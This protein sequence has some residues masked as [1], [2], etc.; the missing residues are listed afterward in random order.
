MSTA[1]YHRCATALAASLAPEA[2]GCMAVAPLSP[3]EM[4]LKADLDEPMMHTPTQRQLTGPAPF[5][6]TTVA[7]P[8]ADDGPAQE[9][10]AALVQRIVYQ[11]EAAL[12]ALYRALCGRVYRQALR[13]VRDAATAEEV[14]EDVFWQVWRQAPRFDAARGPAIAWVLQITRSRSLDAL[15][16]MGR[17]PLREALDI[18]DGNSTQPAAEDGDP[19]AQLGQAQLAAQIERALGELAPLR[20]QLVSLA[21]QRG[22]SQSEIAAEMDLPLGTV[23]SH[24]RRALA[25]MKLVLEPTLPAARRPS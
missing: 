10:L 21:F 22:Y 2:S 14:V 24:L 6:P 20:R 19:Q 3:E 8:P 16:A 17:D 18:D 1:R 12:A 15:R 9:A 25:E 11:D 7:Q 4:G 5:A 13:L 23:K